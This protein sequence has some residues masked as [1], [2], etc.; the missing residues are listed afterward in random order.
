[1]IFKQEPHIPNII[2]TPSFNDLFQTDPT[3][4][5]DADWTINSSGAIGIGAVGYFILSKRYKGLITDIFDKKILPDDFS[6]YLHV[7][8]KTDP[9]M[10]PEGCESMYVL[11]PVTNLLGQ[12]DWKKAGAQFKDKVLVFLE[13]VF[14]LIDLR[15]NLQVCE[16]FTPLDFAKKQNAY[17]GSAWGVEPKLTQTAIFRPHNRCSD[18]DRLYLVGA[19]T[20]PGAGLPGVM[21]TAKTTESVILNDFKNN[22]ENLSALGV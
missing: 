16:M 12:V 20:H 21:L 6:M 7:P 15:K 9:E 18:I 4:A 8:S 2:R 22:H 5:D 19:S 17:L 1:M 11:I 14:G 10:A 13:E 3:N